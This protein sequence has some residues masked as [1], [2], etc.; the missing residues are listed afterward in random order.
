VRLGLR[1]GKRRREPRFW[2]EC[3]AE[4]AP[5]DSSPTGSPGRLERIIVRIRNDSDLPHRVDEAIVRYDDGRV[6]AQWNLNP[7][8]THNIPAHEAFEFAIPGEALLDPGP[9]ARFRVI[10]YRGRS[11]QRQEWSSRE[12]RFGPS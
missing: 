12:S 4:Y 1:R 7:H 6:G 10:A 3:R 8:L 2:I 9:A 11:G 5:G